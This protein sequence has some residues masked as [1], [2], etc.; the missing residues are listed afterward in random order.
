MAKTVEDVRQ[1]VSQLTIFDA[2]IHCKNAWDAVSPETIVK[3]FN[4]SGIFDF[5][6][7]PPCSPESPVEPMEEKDTEFDQY[8]Q[9]LLGIPWDEYLLMDEKLEI[10]KP[11]HAPDANTYNDHTDDL[12]DQDQDKAMEAIPSTEELIKSLKQVQRFVLGNDKLFDITDQLKLGIQN[13]HFEQEVSSKN[14]Q[15][16]IHLL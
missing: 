14:K 12:P 16:T 4:N 7:S 9:N 1:F 13:M 2:I 15:T 8:F 5:D 11:V 6:D 3:C 10:E